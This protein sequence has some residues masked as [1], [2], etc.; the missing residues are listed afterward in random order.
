MANL[1]AAKS[2]IRVGE[3]ISVVAPSNEQIGD[4]SP[5][6]YEASKCMVVAI[7]AA[8]V[9]GSVDVILQSRV[10]QEPWVTAKSVALANGTN[11]IKLMAEVAA[12]QPLLP[13][14]PLVRIVAN[15]A[16]SADINKAWLIKPE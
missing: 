4:V 10:G 12:D 1:Y 8:N 6:T 13:L 9:S 11:Y 3:E 14:L 7:T 5:I 15:G 16:G 2:L